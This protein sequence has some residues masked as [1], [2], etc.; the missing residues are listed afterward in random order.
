MLLA[1]MIVSCALMRII[2]TGLLAGN[3]RVFWH[4]YRNSGANR[5]WKWESTNK[6]SYKRVHNYFGVSETSVRSFIASPSFHKSVGLYGHPRRLFGSTAKEVKDSWPTNLG[7][8]MKIAIK[9]IN[10]EG[11]S[12][13]IH[14]SIGDA[15]GIR[16]GDSYMADVLLDEEPTS[17]QGSISWPE[18]GVT[19]K[20]LVGRLS[21]FLK[22]H[23]FNEGDEIIIVPTPTAIYLFRHHIEKGTPPE[24]EAKGYRG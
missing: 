11:H 19:E 12:F 5:T 1:M 9:Q 21:Q 15:N 24:L 6:C 14:P 16:R 22:D 13:L 4:P 18:T 23:S 2:D 3:G 10:F 7:W 20:T 8:G 17:Y